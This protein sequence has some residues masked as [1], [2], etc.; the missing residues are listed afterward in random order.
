M[1]PDTK[2]GVLETL[3]NF[4][5]E[6]PDIQLPAASLPEH[7]IREAKAR[8]VD[9]QKVKKATLPSGDGAPAPASETGTTS[10]DPAA[11]GL[12]TPG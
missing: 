5:P 8:R 10:V 4:N 6:A 1:Q 7:T 3:L 2:D 9:P 12:P 11:A